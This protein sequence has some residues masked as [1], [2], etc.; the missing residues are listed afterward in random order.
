V[1]LGCDVVDLATE[2]F[3]PLD[4]HRVILVI[5]GPTVSPLVVGI[6]WRCEALVLC[7]KTWV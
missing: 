2:S 5:H 3:I 6:H 4:V 7:G 1:L